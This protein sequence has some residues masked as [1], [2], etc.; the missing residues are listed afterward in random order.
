M[1]ED[2][3]C[4][5]RSQGCFASVFVYMCFM[6]FKTFMALL[7]LAELWIARSTVYSCQ[8]NLISQEFSL[9]DFLSSFLIGFSS[10]LT[11]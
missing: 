1:L 11:K 10:D 7:F 9:L 6:E 5:Q 4:N 3:L 2:S 8:F